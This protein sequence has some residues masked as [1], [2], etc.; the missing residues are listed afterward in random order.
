[1]I[2]KVIVESSILVIPC[3]YPSCVNTFSVAV[4]SFPVTVVS[5]HH[6]V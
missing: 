6:I 5:G 2:L 4:H 1:L 3:G